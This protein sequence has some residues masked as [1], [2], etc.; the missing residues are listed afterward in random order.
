MKFTPFTWAKILFGSIMDLIGFIVAEVSDK[1]AD[2]ASRALPVLSPLPNAISVFYVSQT[3]LGFSPEQAIAF[4]ASMEC[5]LFAMIEVCLMM[6][7]GYDED[8]AKY[9]KP[10]KLVTWSTLGVMFVTMIFV[11]FIELSQEHGHPIMAALPLLS[12]FSAVG[13]AFRRWHLRNVASGKLSNKS[14]IELDKVT[15]ELNQFKNLYESALSDLEVAKNQLGIS[16][17]ESNNVKVEFDKLQSEFDRLQSEFENYK[18]SAVLASVDESNRAKLIDVMNIISSN[19]ITSPSDLVKLG[20]NNEVYPLWRALVMSRL[21][22]K[23]GD[24]A[25]HAVDLGQE[26]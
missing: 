4:S 12:M 18:P 23:N 8:R 1:S 7:D 21:I 25:F 5:A 19:R 9:D 26:N 13:L 20:K 24:G 10:F 17:S 6:F 3:A 22:Y 14:Q 15:S 16:Q 11:I 2:I